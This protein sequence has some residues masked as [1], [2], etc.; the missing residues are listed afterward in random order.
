MPFLQTQKIILLGSIRKQFFSIWTFVQA[1]QILPRSIPFVFFQK[2]RPSK[3]IPGA[4]KSCVFFLGVKSIAWKNCLQK[5]SIFLK[6]IYRYSRFGRWTVV[7]HYICIHV[8]VF[9]L[10]LLDLY[11][12]ACL[13]SDLMYKYIFLNVCFITFQ[14]FSESLSIPVC[15]WCK[16]MCLR[17]QEGNWGSFNQIIKVQLLGLWNA[18]SSFQSKQKLLCHKK[19]EQLAQTLLKANTFSHHSCVFLFGSPV[20]SPEWDNETNP[21][22]AYELVLPYLPHPAFSTHLPAAWQVNQLTKWF[23]QVGCDPCEPH[24]TSHEPPKS[25]HIS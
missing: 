10:K 11:T 21:S 14:S 13:P 9:L 17:H 12:R 23:A 22:V 20:R 7:N 1:Q 2:S 5:V 6:N 16:S 4:L 8:P 24:M 3:N 19:L 15:P 25:I 18:H